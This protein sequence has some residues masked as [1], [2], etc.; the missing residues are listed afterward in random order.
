MLV[1]RQ[2]DQTGAVRTAS[3]L[4]LPWQT[5]LRAAVLAGSAAAVWLV[6][7]STTAYA[8]QGTAPNSAA[9]TVEV[10][11]NTATLSQGLGPVTDPVTGTASAPAADPQSDPQSGPES[12]LESGLRPY[13]GLATG[14]GVRSDSTLDPVTTAVSRPA[15]R[16]AAE[17][18]TPVG[19]PVLPLERVARVVRPGRFAPTAPL[20]RPVHVLPDRVL[21]VLDPVAGATVD[22]LSTG[23][24]LVGSVDVLG[25]VG[26][27]TTPAGPAGSSGVVGPVDL[28]GTGPATAPVGSARRHNDVSP[29]VSVLTDRRAGAPVR[30]GPNR[31]PGPGPRPAG[32]APVPATPVTPAPADATGQVGSNGQATALPVVPAPD[33]APGLG[34]QRGRSG[35]TGLVRHRADDPSITPD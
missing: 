5:V 4:R 13:L 23:G 16:I 18:T 25:V 29:P 9:G 6:C 20:L 7:G 3:V 33:A 1:A 2:A 22:P 35:S 27:V 17:V 21:A 26:P 15:S 14:P 30:H 8:D 19:G 32:P 11:P 28:A 31:T 12:D 24:R 10:G 34:R